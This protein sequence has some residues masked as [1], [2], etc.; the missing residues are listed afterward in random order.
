MLKWVIYTLY[1]KNHIPGTERRKIHEW[2]P[3][4]N[5]KDVCGADKLQLLVSF[6]ESDCESHKP[7]SGRPCEC[8][9]REPTFSRRD[10]GD[11][12]LRDK[13]TRGNDGQLTDYAK[14]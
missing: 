5:P 4:S 10:G 1:A 2:S 7:L 12:E 8:G 9:G 14:D 13:S 11:N 6:G 3:R